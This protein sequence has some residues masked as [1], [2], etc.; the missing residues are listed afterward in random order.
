MAFKIKI[1]G[2]DK[3]I[4][5]LDPNGAD[6]V[7]MRTANRVGKMVKT[8]AEKAIT[9]DYKIKKKDLQFKFIRARKGTPVVYISAKKRPISLSK[10]SARK[11]KGGVRVEVQRGKKKIVSSAFLAEMN[12]GH[13]GVYR[14]VGDKR[15]PIRELPGPMPSSL[16]L[17]DKVKKVM[18]EK[19]EAEWSVRLKREIEYY[20][21]K[22]K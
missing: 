15:L 18:K 21:S 20:Y 7:V 4:E 22:K 8:A 19:A 11:V 13:K 3:L 2:L 14:R 10:F 1:E 12:T 5:T 6:T 17:S 16:L 9:E